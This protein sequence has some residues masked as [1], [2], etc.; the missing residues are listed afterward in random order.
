MYAA[1]NGMKENAKILL[2]NGT[3]INAAD[4]NGKLLIEIFWYKKTDSE[5]SQLFRIKV[6]VSW[7]NFYLTSNMRK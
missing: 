5:T 7:I 6:N 2:E 3:D 4:N 1:E